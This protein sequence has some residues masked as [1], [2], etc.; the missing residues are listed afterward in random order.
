MN[1]VSV[2]VRLRTA[3]LGALV[4]ASIPPEIVLAQNSREGWQQLKNRVDFERYLDHSLEDAPLTAEERAQIYTLIDGSSIHDSFRDDQREE[5]RRVVLSTRVGLIALAQNDSKQILVRGPLQF[6][7]G[8]G[9]CGLWVFM[10]QPGKARLILEEVGLGLLA[11]RESFRDSLISW[12]LSM[13]LVPRPHSASIA[14]T[15]WNINESTVI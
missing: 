2:R 13:I 15:I 14:G 12:C 1:M 4:L 9:N 8:T 10:R 11:G 7:G 3:V 5:E 6:C